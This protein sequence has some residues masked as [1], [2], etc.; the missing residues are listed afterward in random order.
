[1]KVL[2]GFPA[3]ITSRLRARV[4][5]PGPTFAFSASPRLAHDN[6]ISERD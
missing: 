1:M 3:P 6:A 5:N 4:P 2:S